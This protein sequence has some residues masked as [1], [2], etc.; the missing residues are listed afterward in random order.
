MKRNTI[1]EE[2]VNK[3]KITTHFTSVIK[4]KILWKYSQINNL[5]SIKWDSQV[6]VPGITHVNTNLLNNCRFILNI[7]EPWLSLIFVLRCG[8]IEYPLCSF[9]DEIKSRCKVLTIVNLQDFYKYGYPH[10]SRCFIRY[11]ADYRNL[12]FI[13]QTRSVQSHVWATKNST[14]DIIFI[15]NTFYWNSCTQYLVWRENSLT[16]P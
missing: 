15:F 5:S 1:Y 7:A 6:C 3:D 11:L 12:T 16:L 9:A 8:T 2:T 14:N 10:T 4:H 13:L